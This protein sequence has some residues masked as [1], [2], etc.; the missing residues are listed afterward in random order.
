MRAISL[1]LISLLA[2]APTNDARATLTK[3]G[4]LC[5][6]FL[7]QLDEAIATR[8]TAPNLTQA[9]ARRALGAKSCEDSQHKAGIDQ[10]RLALRDL[11]VKPTAK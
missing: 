7:R 9:K 11:G 8:P 1:V 5:A 6:A 3:D 4:E 2:A 10:L